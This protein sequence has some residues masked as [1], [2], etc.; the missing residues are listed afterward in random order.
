MPKFYLSDGE[1]RFLI[2]TN[3][4]LQ[5]CKKALIH[6]QNNNKQIGSFIFFSNT[7]FDSINK[8][9]CVETKIVNGLNFKYEH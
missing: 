3:T 6:W 7:G 4:H 5:A 8:I 2:D 9:N 1:N